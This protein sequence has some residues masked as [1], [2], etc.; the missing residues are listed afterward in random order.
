MTRKLASVQRI[1]K[2]TL[3]KAEIPSVSRQSWLRVVV[4]KGEFQIGGL[5]FEV[6]QLQPRPIPSFKDR[7][8]RIKT[9]K[10]RKQISQG[11]F[12]PLTILP[13]IKRWKEGDDVTEIIGVTKHDPEGKLESTV[14]IAHPVVKFLMKLSWFRKLVLRKKPKGWPSFAKKTDEDRIQLFPHICEQEKGT[15]FIVS[16]KLDGMSATYTIERKGQL[17]SCLAGIL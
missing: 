13:T 4:K 6:P 14:S 2:S 5:Y 7:K 1:M 8:Y 10:L 15:P 12:M 3:L 16:E 17:S 11:L 9:I